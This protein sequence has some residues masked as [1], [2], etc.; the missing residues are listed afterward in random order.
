MN[1]CYNCKNLTIKRQ[2]NY[3]DYLVWNSVD[4][5]HC[6]MRI[7][8]HTIPCDKHEVGEPK[9]IYVKRRDVI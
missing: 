8:N 6:D 1:N 2:K 5:D 7:K 3:K 9:I 4:C